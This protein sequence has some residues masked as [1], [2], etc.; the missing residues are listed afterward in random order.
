M[1]R[2][3]VTLQNN[4]FSGWMRGSSPR[5][6]SGDQNHATTALALTD[7]TAR[8]LMASRFQALMVAISMVRLTEQQGCHERDRQ[9]CR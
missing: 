7:G 1:T 4:A 6:T 3:S 2:P 5:M 8:K 9:Q